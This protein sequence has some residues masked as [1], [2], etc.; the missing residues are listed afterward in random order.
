MQRNHCYRAVERTAH[1]M[2]SWQR[3]DILACLVGAGVTA[4]LAPLIAAA[5]AFA[6]LMLAV[7]VGRQFWQ[8]RRDYLLL[9]TRRLASPRTLRILDPDLKYQPYDGGAP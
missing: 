6:A 5:C 2:V 9:L 3:Q 8:G 1:G 4:L 7:L